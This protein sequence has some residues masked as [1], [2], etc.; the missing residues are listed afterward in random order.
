MHD[1]ISIRTDEKTTNSGQMNRFKL[2]MQKPI[3]RILVQSALW[4]GAM[5]ILKLVILLPLTLG[6]RFPHPL[7]LGN[8]RRRDKLTG[9]HDPRP[10]NDQNKTDPKDQRE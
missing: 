1:E 6:E 10:R 5:L 7:N 3:M 9:R 4:F 8:P 2:F